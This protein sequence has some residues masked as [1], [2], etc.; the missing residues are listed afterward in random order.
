M[1]YAPPPGRP[2][3]SP[4]SDDFTPTQNNRKNRPIKA[5]DVAKFIADRDAGMTYAEIGKKYDRAIPVVW[6][7]INKPGNGK[8]EQM[9]GETK[10]QYGG[11]ILRWRVETDP[12][13]AKA[14]NKAK[15][16]GWKAYRKAAKE[17]CIYLCA[18]LNS[19]EYR[20]TW[21]TTDDEPSN[22]VRK[23]AIERRRIMGQFHI[24]L[25]PH[26]P[27]PAPTPEPVVIEPTPLPAP[28][29]ATPAT[30]SLWERVK[31]TIGTW[32]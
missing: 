26:P 30:L 9:P 11:R 20:G 22:A 8:P 12:D 31:L 23:T 6:K 10:Q 24:Y 29:T 32:F 17:E 13:Y 19:T 16:K 4:P 1:V 18:R 28:V 2:I 14:L 21:V 7:A 15:R 3:S 25:I 5:A 27:A